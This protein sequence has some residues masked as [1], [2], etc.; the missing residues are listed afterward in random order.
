MCIIL[1]AQESDEG[2][3]ELV[4]HEPDACAFLCL[5]NVLVTSSSTL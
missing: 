1:R 3:K 4:R 2:T 5:L